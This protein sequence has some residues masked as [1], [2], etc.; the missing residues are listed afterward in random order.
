MVLA[1]VHPRTGEDSY[2]VVELKQWGRAEPSESGEHLVIADGM[3]G[4]ETLPPPSG[5]AGTASTCAISSAR[6]TASRTL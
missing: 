1:G 4:G 5:F 2:V 6:S 3:G